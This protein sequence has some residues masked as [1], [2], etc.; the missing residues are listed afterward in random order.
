MNELRC[1]SKYEF[2]Y[3]LL[4]YN[5]KLLMLSILKQLELSYFF[6]VFL[7][8]LHENTVLL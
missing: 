8:K 1:E 2:L 5:I 7:L 3:E 6:E 4:Y